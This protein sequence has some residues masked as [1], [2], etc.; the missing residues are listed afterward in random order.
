MNKLFIFIIII[1]IIFIIIYIIFKYFSKIKH[2]Q[3]Y[4]Y[5]C[6]NNY[7]MEQI[8]EFNNL[9]TP[10][11]CDLLI[12]ISKPLIKKSDVM[13]EEKYDKIRTSSHC[14]LNKNNHNKTVNKIISKIDNIIYEKLKIPIENYEDLQ[15]VNYKHDQKY[16]EH[17]DACIKGHI[18]EQD[19]KKMGGYRFATFIIYLNDNFKQGETNFPKKKIKIK[20]KKGKGVL[21]FNLNDDYTDVRINSLHAGL[22]PKNGEKWMCNKW[23]RLNK[24]K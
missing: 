9:L 18:C 22:P 11:E 19:K 23:I 24:I 4:I 17:W 7:D 20:P 2:I 12:N 8:Y 15:V 14:F 21:F 6:S 3:K 16:N 13:S 1:I 10:E 5:D